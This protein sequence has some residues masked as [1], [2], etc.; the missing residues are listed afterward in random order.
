MWDRI[1]GGLEGRVRVCLASLFEHKKS[2]RFFESSGSPSM[3]KCLRGVPT[4]RKL[5]VAAP[6]GGELLKVACWHCEEGCS[7]P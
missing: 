6:I 1:A 2:A 4:L 5:E 3:L 7:R